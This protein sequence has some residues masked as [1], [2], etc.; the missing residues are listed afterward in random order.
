MAEAATQQVLSA[1]DNAAILAS[2]LAGKRMERLEKRASEPPWKPRRNYASGLSACARQMTY[3]HTHYAEREPFG[4]DGVAHME[5]G[6][7]EEKL[8]IQ[9]ILADGFQVV[10]EQ[11][12]L[13]DD[14]YWVTGKIDGK[15]LWQGRRIPFEIKRISP[16]GF[17]QLTT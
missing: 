4:V 8:L 3:A 14:R 16:Y 5:D 9:E 15:L 2:A 12:K 1:F 6:N 13:D 11:V 17:D 10:E 7:H